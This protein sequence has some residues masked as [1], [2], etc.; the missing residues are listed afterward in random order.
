[1]MVINDLY[2]ASRL[3]IN[4]SLFRSDFFCVQD[5]VPQPGFEGGTDKSI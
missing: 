3:H 2:I 4:I 1:M 5:L